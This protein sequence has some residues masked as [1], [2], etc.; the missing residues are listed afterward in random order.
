M[1]NGIQNGGLT[2]STN[3]GVPLLVDAIYYGTQVQDSIRTLSGTT[4]T[5]GIT[6]DPTKSGIIL[7]RNGSKYL[8]FFVN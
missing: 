7:N 5:F 8:N 4:G 2:G 1:T 6:T 3:N